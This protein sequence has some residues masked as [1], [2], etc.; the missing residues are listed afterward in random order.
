MLAKIPNKRI[1]A[2]VKKLRRSYLALQLLPPVMLG[3]GSSFLGANAEDE[4]HSTINRHSSP[5]AEPTIG[6]SET[7][8][9]LLILGVKTGSD[10][11]N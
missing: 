4:Q 8:R 9:L 7:G 1:N 3:V 2:D 10:L 11:T 5:T 6:S